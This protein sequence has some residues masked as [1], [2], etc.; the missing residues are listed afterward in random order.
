[1]PRASCLTAMTK[2]DF[3]DKLTEGRGHRPEPGPVQF[4]GFKSA[5]RSCY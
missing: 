2:K 1:M 5:H 4:P 3:G